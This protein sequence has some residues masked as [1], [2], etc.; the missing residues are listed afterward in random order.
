MTTK[1]SWGDGAWGTGV[2]GIQLSLTSDLDDE[3]LRLWPFTQIRPGDNGAIRPHL[4]V[5]GLALDRTQF[6]I[7]NVKQQQSIDTATGES[8]EKLAG[9][10]NL[11]R[12]TNESDE[13][14]RFRTTIQKAVTRSNGTLNGLETVLAIVFGADIVANMQLSTPS[15]APVVQLIIPAAIVQ[16]SPL[17]R[18]ELE[19]ALDDAIPATD[20][21]RIITDNTFIFGESGDQGIGKGNL[22]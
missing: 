16:D 10:V 21:L 1:N 11:T 22:L 9:E 8:L 13:R 19:A 3:I 5:F 15:S 18:A 14:L 17:T 6:R 2:W 20:R 4:R 7:N 12:E